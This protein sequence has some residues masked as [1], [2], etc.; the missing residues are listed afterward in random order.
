MACLFTL[1]CVLLHGFHHVMFQK[2]HIFKK[3]WSGDVKTRDVNHINY[4]I[5]INIDCLLS[6]K[7][8]I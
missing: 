3:A 5:I 2:K 7:S 6:V 8:R 1:E 4:C